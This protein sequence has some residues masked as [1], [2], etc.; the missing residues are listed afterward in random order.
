[1]ECIKILEENLNLS[2][3]LIGEVILMEKSLID[4]KYTENDFFDKY[5]HIAT[6]LDNKLEKIIY[7]YATSLNYFI[8][9]FSNKN[10]F[11][12]NLQ[13]KDYKAIFTTTDLMSNKEIAK[14]AN[15]NF[16]I[17][18]IGEGLEEEYSSENIKFID[19]DKRSEYI[20]NL[21]ELKFKISK[22]YK[23]RFYLEIIKQN[24]EIEFSNYLALKSKVMQLEE[25]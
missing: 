9:P 18:C 24:H 12:K 19:V 4:E 21:K 8:D 14:L 13:K 15:K 10:D 7:H 23:K 6:I 16:T 17:Y 2:Y 3:S 25:E 22:N 5:I 20:K 11:L 1:M